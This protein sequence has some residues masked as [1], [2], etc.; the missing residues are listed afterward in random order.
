MESESSYSNELTYISLIRK[1]RDSGCYQWTIY[2]FVLFFWISN[3]F[4]AT[5]ISFIFMNPGFDCTT[6][7]V[8]KID[9]EEYVCSPFNPS[10]Q[11]LYEGEKRMESLVTEYGPFHCE[12]NQTIA[13]AR[14]IL[15]FGSVVVMIIF[16]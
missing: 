7:G 1:V 10:E 13:L 15:P 4:A 11:Y 2:I 9:C 6:L 16:G 14:G 3:G 5:S 8:S 12:Q